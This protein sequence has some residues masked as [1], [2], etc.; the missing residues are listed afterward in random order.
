MPFIIDVVCPK[1]LFVRIVTI[2]PVKYPNAGYIRGCIRVKFPNVVLSHEFG[3]L[4]SP[5]G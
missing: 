5:I 3:E 4:S 2:G 1:K